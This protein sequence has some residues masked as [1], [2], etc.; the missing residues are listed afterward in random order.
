MYKG[1]ASYFP[2]MVF[3]LRFIQA[4]IPTYAGFYEAEYMEYHLSTKVTF[5]VPLE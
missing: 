1:Q 4:C 3:I 5:I 2:R